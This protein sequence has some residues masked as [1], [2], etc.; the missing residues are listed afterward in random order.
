MPNSALTPRVRLKTRPS[1]TGLEPAGGR[2]ATDTPWQAVAAACLDDA[3]DAFGWRDARHRLG[4]RLASRLLATPIARL[5][6]RLCAFDG[7]VAAHGLRAGGVHATRAFTQGTTVQGAYTVPP[8]GPLLLVANHPG[9]A[10]AVALFASLPRDDL[11]VIAAPRRLLAALPATRQ[12]LIVMPEDRRGRLSGVRE[13]G[14]HLAS[15][16]AVLTFPG[17]RIEPDPALREGAAAALADWS[18]CVDLFARRVPALRIVPVAVSGVLSPRVCRH[19]LTRLRRPGRDRDWLAATL[20][21]LRA[22][23]PTDVRPNVVFGAPIDAVG[24]HSAGTARERTLDAM[25]DL[26]AAERD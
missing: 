12:R 13:A 14:R 18:G 25:R 24:G 17:G 11:K 8:S 3:L 7:V 20:Q 6:Q 16:G 23:P 1:P 19:P 2:T 22:S 15:G 4:R 21:M 5:A 9:L 26:L 10:D